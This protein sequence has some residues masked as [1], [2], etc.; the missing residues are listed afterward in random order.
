MRILALSPR[1]VFLGFGNDQFGNPPVTL[2]MVITTNVFL[3][4]VLRVFALRLESYVST[5]EEPRL[6]RR[7]QVRIRESLACLR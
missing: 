2:R 7:L 3:K 6:R 4:M 5:L 1:H